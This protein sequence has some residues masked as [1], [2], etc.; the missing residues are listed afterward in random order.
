MANGKPN[1]GEAAMTRKDFAK[2]LVKRLNQSCEFPLFEFVPLRYHIETQDGEAISLTEY[3]NQH[4][5]K[6]SVNPDL[7]TDWIFDD[8]RKRLADHPCVK[9]EGAGKFDYQ[10]RVT[11][12]GPERVWLRK[13]IDPKKS[14]S[15]P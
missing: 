13:P 15:A 1:D 8:L 11:P 3:Y 6:L 10:I 9:P 14:S 12:K 5:S 4:M 2:R 7:N